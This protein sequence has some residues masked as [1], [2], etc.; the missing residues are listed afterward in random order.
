MRLCK[1]RHNL[2]EGVL[3]KSKS[4]QHGYKEGHGVIWDEARILETDSNS[5]HR[6]YRELAH[7]ECLKNLIS[8]S[9]LDISPI[10]IP[11]I[12]DEVIKI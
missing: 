7:M 10:R 8:Q 9:S 6:K 12:I 4:A 3:E 1:Q 2:K 11:V 5:R